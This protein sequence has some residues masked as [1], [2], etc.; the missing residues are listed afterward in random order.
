MKYDFLSPLEVEECI[1]RLAEFVDEQR[2]RRFT[3]RYPRPFFGTLS[4]H[5]LTL[6]SSYRSPSLFQATLRACPRGTLIEGQYRVRP[7]VKLILGGWVVSIVLSLCPL[8]AIPV[9]MAAILLVVSENATSQLREELLEYVTL[10]GLSLPLLWGALLFFSLLLIL[11]FVAA[12]IIR[13]EMDIPRI[14]RLMEEKLQA[15]PIEPEEVTGW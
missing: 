5:T 1:A 8:S 14:S 4:D 12:H 3:F 2:A 9:V 6:W 11:S 10:I 15:R 13:K 7:V